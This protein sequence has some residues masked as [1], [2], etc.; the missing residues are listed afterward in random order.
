MSIR[1]QAD[2]GYA[3]DTFT[4]R[5]SKL[6]PELPATD[7]LLTALVLRSS[8]NIHGVEEETVHSHRIAIPASRSYT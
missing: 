8:L 6:V 3:G 5:E 4:R 2:V 7:H 1:R